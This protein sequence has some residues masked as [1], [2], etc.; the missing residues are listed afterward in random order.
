MGEDP[1]RVHFFFLTSDISSEHIYA[2]ELEKGLLER[3]IQLTD[4]WREADI[5]HLFE[6]NF[7]SMDAINSFKYPSLFQLLHSD[8]PVVVSLDDLYFIGRPEFTAH[9]RLYYP[10]MRAQS[11]LLD[12]VDGTIAISD[13][14]KRALSD[15]TDPDH[16]YTVYH[17]VNE[18][19]FP[20][21]CQR[22]DEGYVLHV[23]LISKRKNP[24][25]IVEMAER[26][27]ERFLIAG[28]GWDE[29]I[30]RERVG[31]NVEVLGYVPEDE[32]IDLYQGASVFYFPTYHEGFG[33]PVLEAMAAKTAVVSS[34]VYSVPE[35]TGDTAILCQP[36]DVDTHLSH[37]E[38]LMT[39]DDERRALATR[40][41]ERAESF[42]WEKAARRTEKVYQDVLART[43]KGVSVGR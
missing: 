30:P 29:H 20:E 18:R 12:R 23:S 14:V 10:N 33:L 34:D 40:A 32:L 13:S 24:K 8:V 19:Y 42:T 27:D 22:T 37:I 17:G 35:V 38:R 36:D 43:D 26:L 25:A 16:L 3:G 2:G 11:W 31:D 7:F 39:D 41:K 15:V 21:D 5:V 6:V 9:P 28:G 1:L 4:D